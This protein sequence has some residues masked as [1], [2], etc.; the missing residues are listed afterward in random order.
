[1]RDFFHF[2]DP[3][4]FVFP[5]DGDF[6]NKF[7]GD[8]DGEALVIN[9]KMR[10][11]ENA[12]LTLNGKKAVYNAKEAIYECKIPLYNFR[13]TLSAIDAKNGARADIVVYKTRDFSKKFYF[14]VDDAIVFLYDINKNPEKYPSIFDHIFLAPFKKAHD[15]YDAC[16]HINL[17]YEFNAESAGDFSSHKEYFNLSMMTDKY[18]EE[19]SANADWLTFSYHANANYPDMPG[20]VID[21]DSFGESIRNVHKEIKRFAGE[22]AL[23][24]ATTMH[25]G[26]SYIEVQ[27]TFRDHG[28]KVQFAS[29]R[30]VD[31]DSAYLG[32]YGRDGL[33]KHIRGKGVD[34]YNNLW[35]GYESDASGRDF[36]KDNFEDVIFCHVDMVLNVIEK[37]KIIPWIDKQIAL[38]P[39]RLFF[40]PMIHEEYF[41][42]DYIAYIPDCHERILTAIDHIYNLGYRSEAIE[43][44]VI[45]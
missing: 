37:E 13:N 30:C 23:V 8:L 32:Y 34:P 6:L 18:K 33:P 27:R 3:V 21:A 44:F 43:K 12:D 45:E 15:L 26:N 35:N 4:S 28:Y 39:N 40:H 20:K 31:N 11:G 5:I 22:K 41:Y 14:T 1:M 42:E 2:H 24:P 19:F 9:V 36:W 29:F 7:D 38:S 10:A 16:V 25:W 17:Y